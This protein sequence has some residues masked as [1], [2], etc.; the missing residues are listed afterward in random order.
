MVGEV[1][2]TFDDFV[3]NPEVEYGKNLK[4]NLK[5]DMRAYLLLVR[6]ILKLQKIP[7]LQ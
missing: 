7:R 6:M 3:A 5:L 1:A 2:M 4:F